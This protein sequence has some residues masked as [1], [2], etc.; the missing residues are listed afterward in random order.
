MTMIRDSEMRR[1]A[2][3]AHPSTSDHDA[4]HTTTFITDPPGGKRLCALQVEDLG[5]CVH[6][7]RRR[8][9]EAMSTKLTT[10]VWT[11]WFFWVTAGEFAGF[12]APALAGALTS[13]ALLLVL[14][15]VIE[16]AVLGAAQCFVLRRTIPRLSAPHWIGVT[17]AAAGFAWAIALFTVRYA[18]PLGSMPL[19]MLLSVAAFVGM[20]LLL[21]MGVGQWLVLHHH[22]PRASRWVWAN[23]VAWCA[24][25]IVFTGVTTPLW[26]PGQPTALIVLIGA[27]GGLLMAATMAAITGSALVRLLKQVSS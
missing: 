12:L 21:S 22:V 26:Q 7:K 18:E 3:P 2:Q 27:L 10:S 14:A 5:P 23:A 24:G 16:G 19:P 1:E 25:L 11:T 15:G 17:A 6:P 8:T 20:S 4:R 13:S 9:V